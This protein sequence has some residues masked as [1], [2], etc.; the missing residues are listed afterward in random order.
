MKTV[1]KIAAARAA[2]GALH[3]IR[4]LAGLGDELVATR[5]GIRFALDLAQGI[6]L[7]IYLQGQFEPATARSYAR[8]VRAGDLAIDIG[9]NIGGH[10]LNLARLVGPTGRVIAVEP[11]DNAFAKLERN[12]A[13]N[14]DLARRVMARRC[15][16]AATDGAAAPDFVYSTWPLT[17]QHGLHPKHRGAAS[18]TDTVPTRSLDSLLAEI[19]DERRVALVKMDVDGHE[20]DVLAG[21]SRLLE[22]DRPVFVMELAPY[23]LEE[24]GA[25]L[26][27]LLD[28]FL[29]LGY[30]FRHETTG[31]ALPT[32]PGQ[33]ARM[34][35]DGGGIN[36]L[37]IADGIGTTG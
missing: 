7:A 8:H 25:S 30:S 32:D 10:T 11:T 18:P 34:I 13:L 2:Y 20:C 12:L 1:H 28:C 22:R 24:C 6:D 35:G 26:G 16:L 29:G 19:G 14:P 4:G 27:A 5:R 37:A 21:A 31:R 3:A 9:A 33:L 23:A 15:F 17:H 36:A